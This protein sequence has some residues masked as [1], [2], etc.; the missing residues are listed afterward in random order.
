MTRLEIVCY[1]STAIVS[2]V[3]Q[4]LDEFE[5]KLVAMESND[6]GSLYLTI[7]D[8][9]EGQL[10]ALLAKFRYL[11]SISDA[12]VVGTIPSESSEQEKRLLLNR[13]L[14]PVLLLDRNGIILHGNQAFIYASGLTREC[15]I[16]QP[17]TDF[18]KGFSFGRWLGNGQGRAENAAVYLDGRPYTAQIEPVSEDSSLPG[19]SA[20]MLVLQA[21][22]HVIPDLDLASFRDSFAPFGLVA[23][24]PSYVAVIDQLKQIADQPRPILLYGEQGS[25]RHFSSYLLNYFQG[26]SPEQAIRI[27]GL[28]SDAILDEQL[29][30]IAVSQPTMV[31]VNNIEALEVEQFKRLS[32]QMHHVVQVVFVSAWTPN[33]LIDRFGSEAFYA[34]IEQCLEVLPLRMRVEDITPLAQAWVD[35]QFLNAGKVSP[36]LS[37][38]VQQFLKKCS[39]PGNIAQLLQ[40]LRDTMTVTG[41]RSWA[42]KDIQYSH[43]SQRQSMDLN[44]ILNQEYHQAMAEFEKM[45]ISY[46]YPHFPSTRSLAKKL[47]LSHT[48]VA[49]KLREHKIT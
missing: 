26:N 34:A 1:C 28:I 12:R 14:A 35:E 32:A 31:I 2:K 13:V 21:D 48:A 4:I 9:I 8:V 23:H 43:Q 37:K 47:G 39:W 6:N 29:L 24:H 36:I 33:Q 49:K 44:E 40:V 11:D 25:G 22:S 42:V 45:F 17:V 18:V 5:A 10:P 30:D 38:N 46:H 19:Q 41:L 7:S 27:N 20:A 3:C 15:F 16:E